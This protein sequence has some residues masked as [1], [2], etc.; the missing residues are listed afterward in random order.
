MESIRRLTAGGAARS[1]RWPRRYDIRTSQNGVGR[2]RCG[3]FAAFRE[4]SPR[5]SPGTQGNCRSLHARPND[6]TRE[7]PRRGSRHRHRQRVPS[8]GRPIEVLASGLPCFNGAQL[9]VD[10]TLCSTLRADGTARP[11]AHW[12]DGAA[13]ED[14]KE[15]KEETYPELVNG[16]RCRLQ[17]LGLETGGRMPPEGP[18][19]L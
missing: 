17:V 8:I 15:R 14:A 5:T 2:R 9:A 16:R 7:A 13:L 18:T 12:Q 11:R 19:F 4:P 3:R 6:G 1:L 10:V